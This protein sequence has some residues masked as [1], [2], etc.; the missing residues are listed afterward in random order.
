MRGVARVPWVRIELLRFAG[1]PGTS[2]RASVLCLRFHAIK[3]HG[4]YRAQISSRNNSAF[5]A[6]FR[7]VKR[8]PQGLSA[9]AKGELIYSMDCKALKPENIDTACKPNVPL[10]DTVIPKSGSVQTPE[11]TPITGVNK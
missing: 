10:K 5:S 11:T 6:G 7:P 9:S 4:G 3:L 8:G 1:F 2:V